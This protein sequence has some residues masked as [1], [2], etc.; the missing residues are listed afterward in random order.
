MEKNKNKKIK[1]HMAIKEYIPE[2]VEE[3]NKKTKLS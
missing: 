2:F 3:K 1:R